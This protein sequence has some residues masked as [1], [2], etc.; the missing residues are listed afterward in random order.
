MWHGSSKL[1]W[2]TCKQLPCPVVPIDGHHTL[3]HRSH[4]HIP[5]H[6]RDLHL[7]RCISPNGCLGAYIGATSSIVEMQQML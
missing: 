3:S 6:S 2:A 1:V 4:T 7:E 5:H